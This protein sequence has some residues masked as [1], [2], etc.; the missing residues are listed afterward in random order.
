MTPSFTFKDSRVVLP[1]SYHH[2]PLRDTPL[3]PIVTS[4]S[5]LFDALLVPQS[6]PLPS[7]DKDIYRLWRFT[8]ITQDNLPSQ[9]SFNTSTKSLLL[10]KFQRLEP[11]YLLGPSFSLPVIRKH[12]LKSLILST[13]WFR[14]CVEQVRIM[15]IYFSNHG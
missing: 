1:L 10:H 7:S 3:C 5:P 11:G 13:F 4:L 15:L 6:L 14:I 12:P 2:L 8:W 9:K